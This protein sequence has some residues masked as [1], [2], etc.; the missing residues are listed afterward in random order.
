MTSNQCLQES[1]NAIT[2]TLCNGAINTIEQLH[3]AGAYSLTQSFDLND[4]I[5]SLDLEADDL[6]IVIGA[7]GSIR[8]IIGKR[9]FAEIDKAAASISVDS[10]GTNLQAQLF[11]SMIVT[12]SCEPLR[13][14]ALDLIS[15]KNVIDFSGLEKG[16]SVH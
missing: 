8:P 9:D 6:A 10:S 1:F 5:A 11:L 14:A 2:Q 12:G 16:G 7:D 15:D 3:K 4:G 13:K